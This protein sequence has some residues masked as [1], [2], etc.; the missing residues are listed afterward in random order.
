MQTGRRTW[1]WRSLDPDLL[2][3]GAIP[4]PGGAFGTTCEVRRGVEPPPKKA[5]PTP[6]GCGREATAGAD[7]PGRNAC[8][9]L[10]VVRFLAFA[11]LRAAF[12]F[13]VFLAAERCVFLAFVAI[14]TPYC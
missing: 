12:L 8:A 10:L 3:R 6:E 5:T 7:G 14:V 13:T 2:S 11:G 9:Y 4:D 1:T